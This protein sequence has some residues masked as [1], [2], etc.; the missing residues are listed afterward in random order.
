ML[1]NSTVLRQIL[2]KFCEFLSIFDNSWYQKKKIIPKNFQIDFVFC[3]MMK[4]A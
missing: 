2:I 1:L 3:F 4:N